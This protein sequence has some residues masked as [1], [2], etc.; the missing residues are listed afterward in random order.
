V[1]ELDLDTEKDNVNKLLKL[2]RTALP[3]NNKLLKTHSKMTE[4][5][6]QESSFKEITCCS[7]CLRSINDDNQCSLFCKQNGKSRDASNVVECVTLDENNN[8]LKQ[9]IRRNKNLI[10]NY[11]R[12]ANQLLP[13]DI[14]S[15][16][17]YANRIHHFQTTTIDTFPITLMLD[18]DGTPIVKWSHKHT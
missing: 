9:T 15:G 3:P 11:P 13:C 16:T 2:I 1:L 7:I 8:H 12:F 5:L 14:L 6:E 18:I 4:L 10:I 17:V